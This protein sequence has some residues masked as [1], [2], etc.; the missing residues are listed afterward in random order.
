MLANFTVDSTDPIDCKTFCNQ[1]AIK[2]Y[3]I[4]RS[5]FYYIA[6]PKGIII[7]A[8]EVIETRFLDGRTAI[9]LGFAAYRGCLTFLVGQPHIFCH[10][11]AQRRALMNAVFCFFGKTS[12][13]A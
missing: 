6:I 9:M 11:P 12:I 10:N 5:T 1:K 2:L 3:H 13:N 7:T 8:L 4:I